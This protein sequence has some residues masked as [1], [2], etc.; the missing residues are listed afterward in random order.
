MKNKPDYEGFCKHLE[1][2]E[3]V[4]APVGSCDLI[5]LGKQYNCEVPKVINGKLVFNTI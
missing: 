5:R 3:I 4:G 2:Y 1:E